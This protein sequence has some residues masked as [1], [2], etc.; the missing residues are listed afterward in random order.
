VVGQR[1]VA[2]SGH[3]AGTPRMRRISSTPSATSFN[4]C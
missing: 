1:I 4:F 2:T 3:Q